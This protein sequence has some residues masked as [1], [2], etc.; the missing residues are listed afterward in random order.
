[1]TEYPA[2]GASTRT[3]VGR[4]T[5]LL[6]GL[7]LIAAARAR[8]E[9]Y[10]NRPVKIIVPTVAGGTVDVVT[11]LIANDLSLRLG[12]TF[13]VD[14]RSGAGNTLGSREAARSDP[15]GYTLLMSSASGQVI[16]PL[17]YKAVDY[18]AVKSFAPIGL[19]A[20]SSII[21]VINPALPFKSLPELVAYAKANPGRLNYGSAGTGTVPHLTGEL[22]KSAA[23]VDLVHVPY[24]GG[25]LSIADVIA[26]NVQL[27]F[28]ASS[29][30]LQHI[31]DGRLRALAVTS[32]ARIPDLPDVPSTTESGYPDLV[33]TTWTGLFAPAGTDAAV[34]ARLNGVINEG[35][36]SP[37]LRAALA[38]VGNI[39]LGGPSEALAQLL[40][41]EQRKWAPVVRALN[42]KAEP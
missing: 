25:A 7:G 8:A 40:E 24:R 14:N 41:T 22:F 6:G 4:R 5:V 2:S 17:V 35:L 29:P 36:R 27:T 13:F 21:L 30:L 28:E 12:S 33:V 26:G 11:R 9:A 39:P 20:E 31:R 16:S 15:D 23:G 1:M 38:K 3:R 42:L 34:I 32:K 10:P 19:I 37:E 18:D